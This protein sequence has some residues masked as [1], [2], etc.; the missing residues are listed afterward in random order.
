M[1]DAKNIQLL[2]DILGHIHIEN[3]HLTLILYASDGNI[4]IQYKKNAHHFPHNYLMKL[5]N[6]VTSTAE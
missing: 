6:T 2:F 5:Q 3:L 1:H 4:K